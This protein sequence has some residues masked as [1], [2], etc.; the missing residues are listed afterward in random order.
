VK[1]WKTQD[2]KHTCEVGRIAGRSLYVGLIFFVGSSSMRLYKFWRLGAEWNGRGAGVV[3]ARCDSTLRK[4]SSCSPYSH[5]VSF[6][7]LKGYIKAGGS[8]VASRDEDY[9]LGCRAVAF[10]CTSLDPLTQAGW[11]HCSNGQCGRWCT[12]VACTC[13]VEMVRLRQS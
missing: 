1:S 3:W 2:E 5:S 4:I 8:H 6:G 7:N 9:R 13:K 10:S 12:A 11:S